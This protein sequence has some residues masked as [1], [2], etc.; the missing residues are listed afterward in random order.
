MTRTRVKI[1]GITRVEDAVA[2]SRAGADAIGMVFYGSSPR[3]IDTETAVSIAAAVGPFVTTVA[4]F[5]NAG[6][7]AIDEV[8]DRVRPQLLQFHGDEDGDF[9]E[10][11]R[12][13]YIKAIRVREDLDLGAQMRR[14][15]RAA[16]FLFDAW[17]PDLYGGTGQSFD[18]SLLNNLVDVPWILAGGLNEDNVGDAIRRLA[19][20]AVDVSG[21]VETSPGIKDAGRMQRFIG[22]AGRG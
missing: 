17:H 16:G 18:W 10:S 14:Y 20:Y 19:P 15:P 22:A 3:C 11:F 8:L 9:C 12:R 6:K 5:V 2:A 4:L 13:P 1:C 21:G 7:S